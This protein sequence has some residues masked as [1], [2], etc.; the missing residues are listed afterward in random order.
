M[1][2]KIL[3][4]ATLLAA[5]FSTSAQGTA[6][7]YKRAFSYPD[8]MK[9][10]V[11]HSNVTPQWIGKSNKFW[12]INY[13]LD[14]RTYLLVDAKNKTKTVLFDHIKLAEKLSESTKK[15]VELTQLSLPSLKVSDNLDTLR[16]VRKHCLKKRL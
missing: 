1:M 4:S 10:K 16:F 5:A 7:D 2:K 13:T 9:D 15:K 12:Y 11:F 6:E 8:R 14:G 3:L